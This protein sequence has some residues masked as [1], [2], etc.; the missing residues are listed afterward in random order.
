MA[1]LKALKNGAAHSVRQHLKIPHKNKLSIG[2]ICLLD[3]FI[4]LLAVQWATQLQA[5]ALS[6]PSVKRHSNPSYKR[7]SFARLELGSWTR[8]KRFVELF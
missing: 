5:P 7:R 6:S 3:V 1:G 8:R 2:N 4:Q